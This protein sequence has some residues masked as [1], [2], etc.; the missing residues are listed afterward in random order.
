MVAVRPAAPQ[1]GAMCGRFVS[2]AT[3]ADLAD[4]FSVDEVVADDLGAR[5][6]VAPTDEAYIVAESREGLRRLGTARWG[7]VPFWS[8]GPQGAAKMI[9]ARSETLLSKFKRTF[10][11]RRCIVPADGFYEWEKVGGRKQPWHIH[12]SDGQPFAF[13]GLWEAWYPK[14]SEGA[15]GERLVTC[16][17]ITTRANAVVAPLH[18]RM[19]AVLPRETWGPWLDP[20]ND[21]LASLQGLLGPLDDA[22]VTREAVSTAVNSVRNDGPELL[23]P[24]DTPTLDL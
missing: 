17:I 1:N 2:H 14:D 12:R 15:E 21:D 20:A 8:D 22:L 10:E 6:N 9:N 16:S 3:T 18:D 7:L 4:W 5:Y 24:P 19:P 23:A 11:K 13:A